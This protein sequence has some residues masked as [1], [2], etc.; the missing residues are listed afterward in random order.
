MQ[1][2]NSTTNERKLGTYSS[3]DCPMSIVIQNDDDDDD[4]ENDRLYSLICCILVSDIFLE[5]SLHL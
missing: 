4:G 5:H 2:L 3:E 1:S